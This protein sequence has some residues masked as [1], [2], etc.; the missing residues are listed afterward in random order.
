MRLA[1]DLPG[2]FMSIRSG[3][4]QTWEHAENTGR[5]EV[6]FSSQSWERI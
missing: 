3:D 4:T 5:E 2:D 6:I 1:G